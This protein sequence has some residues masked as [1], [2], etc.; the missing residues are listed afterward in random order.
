MTRPETPTNDH[1]QKIATDWYT[2]GFQAGIEAEKKA[3]ERRKEIAG[4]TQQIGNK[5]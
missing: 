2:W 5:A 3:A 1:D 4:V